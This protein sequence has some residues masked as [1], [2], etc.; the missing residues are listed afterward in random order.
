MRDDIWRERLCRATVPAGMHGAWLSPR[1]AAKNH[2][3]IM[4]APPLPHPC[5]TV[6][7]GSS[8]VKAPMSSP[9]TSWL[10][11]S[12][13][14]LGRTCSCLPSPSLV[15]LTG[16]AASTPARLLKASTSR[17]FPA[18]RQRDIQIGGPPGVA[19]GTA[20]Q[21]SELLLLANGNTICLLCFPALL[22]RCALRC[23]VH[24]NPVGT[25][26]L[27]TTIAPHSMLPRLNSGARGTDGIAAGKIT[28][29]MGTTSKEYESGTARMVLEL[30]GERWGRCGCLTCMAAGMHVCGRTRGGGVQEESVG[31]AAALY[32]EVRGWRVRA[33][34]LG[35]LL[36]GGAKKREQR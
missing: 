26:H 20:P 7:R 4:R 28:I 22:P 16:A 15:P 33:A 35:G 29:T 13:S 23:S 17:Q 27:T 12:C 36:H 30:F 34:H 1:I 24:N 9:A 11:S 10:M 32:M 6:S 21:V 8:P 31:Q 3:P 5:S 18:S 14:F 25:S 2:C 19:D